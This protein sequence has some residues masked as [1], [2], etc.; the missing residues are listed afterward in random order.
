MRLPIAPAS[1]TASVMRAGVLR[2]KT[3]KKSAT[4]ATM[5]TTVK[6]VTTVIAASLSSNQLNAMPV[7]LVK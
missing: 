3:V 1:M 6:M 7:F 5:S 2:L 4:S